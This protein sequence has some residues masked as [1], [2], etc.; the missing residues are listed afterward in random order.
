MF[1]SL[2]IR[3]LE[4]SAQSMEISLPALQF[5]TNVHISDDF[6]RP[7]RLAIPDMA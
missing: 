5:R 1:Q 2:I 6:C 3:R 7:P 4:V